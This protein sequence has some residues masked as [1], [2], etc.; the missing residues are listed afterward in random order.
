[1][2]Y[3]TANQPKLLV[4]SLGASPAF[5]AYRSTNTSTDILA[6]NFFSDGAALGMQVGDLVIT[7][8]STGFIPY[9]AA[10]STVNASSA[11]TVVGSSAA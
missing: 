7:V 9:L 11:A 5:W 3:S 6:S 2:A 10:V 1:M 8:S 4:P